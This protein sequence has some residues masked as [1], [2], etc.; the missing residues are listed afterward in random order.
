MSKEKTGRNAPCPCGSGKKY[1]KCCGKS[2]PDS[3]SLIDTIQ[4]NKQIAY[5][6]SIGHRREETCIKFIE[7]RQN[8]I[9]L[10][11][12]GQQKQVAKVGETISCHE[13]CCFCCCELITARLEECEAIVYYLYHNE[14][15]LLSFLSSFDTWLNAVQKN[16]SLLRRIQQSTNELYK[17]ETMKQDM[18]HFMELEPMKARMR[19]LAAYYDLQIPCPFLIEKRCS[20][21]K[22]RPLSCVSLVV[23][24][25]AENCNPAIRQDETN[26]KMYIFDAFKAK[27]IVKDLAFWDK[28]LA[29]VYGDT[30]PITVYQLLTNSYRFLSTL[31]GLESLFNEFMR[32][33]EVIQ[34]SKNLRNE[35]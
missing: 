12:E 31:P 11:E 34:F 8:V 17:T 25:P 1:K 20:I 22:I 24:S 26:Y 10:L 33:P 13:G 29:V 6:G 7:Q 3:N 9:S 35:F 15:A 21:Y 28:R 18:Q 5:I 16:E 2:S 32:D 4:F 23:T 27:D 19:E 14:K 30:M